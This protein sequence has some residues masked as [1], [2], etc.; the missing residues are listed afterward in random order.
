VGSWELME[1]FVEKWGFLLGGCEVLIEGT[2]RWRAVRGE[3][4]INSVSV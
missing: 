1:G 2:N 4:A 3:G